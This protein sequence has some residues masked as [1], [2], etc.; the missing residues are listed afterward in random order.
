MV[1]KLTLKLD[2]EAI[3]QAKRY[4]ERRRVSLSKIVERYFKSLADEERPEKAE[5]SPLVKELSGIINLK[6]NVDIKDEYTD[7]L[8][9]KYK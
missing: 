6:G 2:K 5:Y 8:I 7:Y 9:D 1:T 3:E 4:A